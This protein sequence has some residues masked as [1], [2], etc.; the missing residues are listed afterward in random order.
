M[1]KTGSITV[2]LNHTLP[3]SLYYSTHK[4]FKSHIK[5]SQDDFSY[6]FP[7]AISYRRLKSQL[8]WVPRYIAVAR[9]RITGNTSR[10]RYC[11]VTASR[12][13]ENTSRD[14]YTLLCD[15]T[16]HALYNNG[17][18]SDTKKT[19]PQYCCVARVLERVYRAFAW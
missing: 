13:T 5:S 14:P 11:C 6:E 1:Y 12:I 17:L 18:C 15:V 10:D 9:I 7:V 19:L 3:T 8:F 4:G 16:S 2:S